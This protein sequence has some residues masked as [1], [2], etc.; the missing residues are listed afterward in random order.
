VLIEVTAI[1]P[2]VKLVRVVDA[3]VELPV[4]FKFKAVSVP[5]LVEEEIFNPVKFAS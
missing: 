5:L 4:T 1:F 3:K 2:A